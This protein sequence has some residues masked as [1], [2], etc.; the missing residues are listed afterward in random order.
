MDNNDRILPL[1]VAGGTALLLAL[2]GFNGVTG[3][4]ASEAAQ[5]ELTQAAETVSTAV[6]SV[7]DTVADTAAAAGEAVQEIAE[8]TAEAVTEAADDLVEETV[9]VA[10]ETAVEVEETAEAVVDA[11]EE[12]AQE[13]VE[14]AETAV[15]D[16]VEVAE[17]AA[18]EVEETAEAT[19][20]ATEETVQETVEAAETVVEEVVEATEDAAVEVEQTAEAVVESTEEAAQESA[21][22]VETA[23]EDTIE[24]TEDAAASAVEVTEDAVE[25][26]VAAVSETAEAAG[27]TAADGAALAGAAAASL[28]DMDAMSDADKA[29]FGAQVR[30]YLMANPEVIIEAV[31]TLEQ[32]QAEAQAAADV[33][34]VQDNLEALLNDPDSWVG[35]NPE[36][37]VTIVEFMDYRCSFCRRAAP[38]VEELI[39][40]D[41]NIRLIVKEL[42]ILGQA[43]LVSSR[44]A[45]AARLAAG[46]DAYKAV[47]DAL[48]D[49]NGE[50]TEPVLRRVAEGLELDA[51]AIFAAMNDA[52]VDEQIGRT[53]ALA[54]RMQINGTPTFVF[55]DQLVRGYVPL[56]GMRQIVDEERAAASE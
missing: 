50:P 26:S 4:D 17:E 43:S 51:D 42:P 8:D 29:A 40:S 48:M 19:V 23:V 11:T 18:V 10:E 6:D 47:H 30:A 1:S 21:A 45:I 41:G 39:A 7:S 2:A 37:D 33:H 38:E 52:S 56:D 32:R 28:F 13:A 35:G 16:T 3:R 53:R 12:T 27:A 44:F 24:A 15:E 34:L 5:T 54:Q 49:L 46:P 22:S 20:E 25:D 36:G 31:N 14:A 55:G 9:E